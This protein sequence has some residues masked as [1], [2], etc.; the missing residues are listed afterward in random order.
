MH[1]SFIEKMEIAMK[2]HQQKQQQQEL[3]SKSQENKDSEMNI[4]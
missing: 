4:A 2:Y 1:K 3:E